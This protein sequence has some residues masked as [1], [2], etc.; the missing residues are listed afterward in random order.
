VIEPPYNPY[1][2]PADAAGVLAVDPSGEPSRQKPPSSYEGERRNV[3]VLLLLCVVTLGFYPTYWYLRRARFLD[4]VDADVKLGSLPWVLVAS[5]AMLV[6]L[7]VMAA[8]TEDRQMLQIAR[9]APNAVSLF[10][11]FR[12]ARI[13]RSDF[14]RTG[15]RVS[16][17][18]VGVFFFGCLYLQHVINEAADDPGRA[19]RRG[20]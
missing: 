8:A 7:A 2:P 13:L 20:S 11:A 14:A 19:G 16:I 1:A 12:T 6:V 9:I 17:S 5:Y 15:R 18:S 10:L 4:S 3:V